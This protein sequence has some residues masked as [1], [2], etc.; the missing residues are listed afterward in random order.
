M[1]EKF[2]YDWIFLYEFRI[3]MCFNYLWKIWIK[4]VKMKENRMILAFCSL[5][6][7]L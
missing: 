1:N 4:T 6:Y 7:L 2:K 3:E 5:E